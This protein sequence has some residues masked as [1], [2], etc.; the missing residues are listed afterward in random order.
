VTE[1]RQYPR[2]SLQLP[3]VFQAAGGVRVDALC[4]DVSLGGM[5]L[6][7]EAPAAYGAE[8]TVYVTL[9]GLRDTAA[10]KSTVRWTQKGS[11]MGVQFGVMGAR[12]THAL[13]ALIQGA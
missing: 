1:H 5:F 10:V 8:V 3:V 2:R 13:L 9:P 11:G 6:E 7:T 12:E 4:R